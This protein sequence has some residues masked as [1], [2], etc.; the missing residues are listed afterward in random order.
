MQMIKL[1]FFI[2]L[3]V[4]NVFGVTLDERRERIIQIIDQELSE[5]KR[6]SDQ[7]R[8]RDPN[9]LLRMAELNLEKA[10]LWRD[11][12]NKEFL[13]LPVKTRTKINKS[14]YFK[15]SAKFFYQANKICLDIARRFKRYGGLGDVYYILGYNAKEANNLKLASKYLNLASRKTKNNSTTKVKSQ[16]SLAE[17][18]YNQ[19]EYKKAIPQYESALRKYKDK[20]YTKDSFN[21]AWCYYRVGRVSDAI[22]KMKEIHSLSGNKKYIDMAEDVERDIGT[23]YATS[24]RISEGIKFYQKLNIEFT[25]KLLR[26]GVNL[27]SQGKFTDAEKVFNYAKK[28]E[29]DSSKK[30]DILLEQ[31]NLYSKYANYNKHLSTSKQ[32][33]DLAAKKNITKEQLTSF[34]YQI[35]KMSATLQ[36][37]VIGKTYK[38]LKKTRFA[39]ARQA[40]QYFDILA[41]IHKDKRSEYDFLKA[42][43]AFVVGMTTLS[44]SY[45]KDAFENSIKENNNKFKVQSMEGMLAV[46]SKKSRLKSSDNIY[47]F[48]A[49]LKH[50]PKDKRTKS[51]YERLF[52]NYLDR[53]DYKNAKNTL[54]R[55][56]ESYPQDFKLQEAMISNLM[57]IDRKKNDS[58]AIRG[59]VKAIDAKEYKVSGKYYQKL[60][61]LLTSLQIKDVQKD[62][63]RGNKKSALVGYHNVLTDKFATPR[64]KI[65]A[66]YNLA[67]LYYELG[68]IQNSFKWSNEAMTKMDAKDV[69][70]FSS[71]FVTI[72]NF[73]FTQF[74]YEKSEAL[75][76]KYLQKICSINTSRK[77]TVFRNLFFIQ[78][79]KHKTTEAEKTLVLGQRCRVKK[80][81]LEDAQYELMREY[82][83]QQSWARYEKYAQSLINSGNYYPKVIEDLINLEEIFDQYNNQTK[84]NY[85]SKLKEKLYYKAKKEKRSLPISVLNHFAA[86]KLQFMK[87][88]VYK[89]DLIK[90]SFPEETFN[91][92]LKQKLALLE[93]LTKRAQD[94]HSTASGQGIIQSYK[95]LY[96][97]HLKLSNEINNFSPTGKSKEYVVSFKQSMKELASQ[98]AM[99]AKNFK[100]EA[101]RTSNKNKIL[102]KSNFIFMDGNKTG[103]PV[104]Y[105]GFS[106]YFLMERG[107]RR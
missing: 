107:G 48:E 37:Q 97:E 75:Y 49:Y 100:N 58:A 68:D 82:K 20:W 51:I 53:G 78:L 21:L 85:Y 76:S 72:A 15:M 95:H 19:K 57:E 5:V 56:A 45:Y 46:L 4:G 81:V 60:Q 12:E 44:F 39:K 98:L 91:S 3:I 88:A 9:L 6:I 25:D 59:W 101:V 7:K 69:L 27:V 42:E 94:V 71:S 41:L 38:R 87:Q 64:S 102:D 17:V 93:D 63:D 26:I 28:Y 43:T 50:F 2:F 13:N 83:A 11:K 62:L 86:Q 73:M 31:L 52:K 40:I 34:L 77:S 79:A 84:K 14:S 10:R 18:Y 35:K 29:K 55:Y 80:K 1:I 99:A 8:G 92:K 23:F 16:I 104:E 54:D 33:Y 74:E 65:N 70:N 47:V 106:N 24:G 61:E 103:I 66:S 32:I 36:R 67:A 90:L 22:R 30:I 96:E 105:S 89:L